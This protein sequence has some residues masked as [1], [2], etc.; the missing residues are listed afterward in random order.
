MLIVTLGIRIIANLPDRKDDQRRVGHGGQSGHIYLARSGHLNFA[1]YTHTS[2]SWQV[3]F[4]LRSRS[5]EDFRLIPDRLAGFCRLFGERL[6]RSRAGQFVALFL[7][8]SATLAD[9]FVRR[10]PRSVA[11]LGG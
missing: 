10:F 6:L 7:A 4:L 2:Q 11:S 1:P 8:G 5:V 3:R 9:Y